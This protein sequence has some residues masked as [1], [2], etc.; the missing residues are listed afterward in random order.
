MKGIIDKNKFGSWAIIT[1]ASSGIGEEFAK[2]LAAN[3]ISLVLVARRLSLLEALGKKLVKEH[4]IKYRI[5]EV[6]LAREDAIKKITEATDDIEIGLLISNAGSNRPGKFFE[7]EESELKNTLQLNLISHLTF[8]HFFGRKMAKRRKGGILLTGAMIGAY[9][10]PYLANEGATK[11]YIHTL[12]KALHTEFKEF[13]MHITVLITPPTETPILKQVGL[14]E[15]NMPM[16]ALPV[17]QC[18]RESLLALG[19]NKI[20]V[21]PGLKFKIMNAL[22]PDSISREM[23]GK[24]VKNNNGLN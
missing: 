21:I 3:G 11:G 12:G 4:N 20:T 19:K 2:Q 22:V 14:T 10:V 17:A 1:G 15:K 23:S 24:M 16:K 7:F 5:V 13:G 18:V 8:V 9:G 6:D